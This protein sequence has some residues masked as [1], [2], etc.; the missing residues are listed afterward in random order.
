MQPRR[1]RCLWG[2]AREGICGATT[3]AHRPLVS[4]VRQ[5]A[6]PVR[7]GPHTWLVLVSVGVSLTLLGGC[8][9]KRVD[10]VKTGTVSLR[11]QAPEDL[12][13]SASAYVEDGT[14]V[15]V[16][17]A[18]GGAGAPPPSSGHVDI[19]V[20]GP[21]GHVLAA[22][23]VPYQ[24][25]SLPRR[26]RGWSATFRATFATAPPSGAIIILRHHPGVHDSAAFE[27]G[28]RQGSCGTTGREPHRHF[29]YSCP[30]PEN[31]KSAWVG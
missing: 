29:G 24:V 16:G 21:A 7:S 27:R 31:V 19:D 9:P 23:H 3:G 4:P 30:T 2:Q 28:Q 26:Q 11:T 18:R 12:R 15:I 20:T 17:A 25:V 13:L 1:R 5:P 6:I 14:F 8:M 10:L 22:Q